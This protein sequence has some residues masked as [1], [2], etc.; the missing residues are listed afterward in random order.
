MGKK[1]LGCGCLGLLLI[2]GAL[3]YFVTQT[4]SGQWLGALIL[5][6]GG[7]IVGGAV[8]HDTV[9]GV[10]TEVKRIENPTA[11]Q[12]G[13]IRFRY[14]DASGTT[15]TGF[16]RVMYSTSKFEALDVGDEIAVWVC[17]SDPAIVKLVGY[18]THE[19]DQCP[20][21]NTEEELSAN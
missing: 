11:I 15:R 1:L 19:P 9:P 10:I 7:I 4:E 18:G 5:L 21:S 20:S 12:A 8:M 13:S 3:A 2:G 14:E 6:Y 16:R 17:K